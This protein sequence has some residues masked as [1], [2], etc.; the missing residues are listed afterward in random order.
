MSFLITLLQITSGAEVPS[1]TEDQVSIL[2]LLMK[3]GYVM[4]PILFLSVL[5]LY[6]FIE[7]LL[8]INSAG[9]IDDSF[10]DRIQQKLNQ[11]DVKGAIESCANQKSPIARILSRGLLRLGSPVR[12]IESAIESTATVEVAKMEEKLP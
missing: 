6:L 3:G 8:Y 9:K 2:G 12:D 11:G 5:S 1:V 10:M 7:R 4:I